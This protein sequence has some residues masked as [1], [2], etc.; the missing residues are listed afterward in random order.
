LYYTNSMRVFKNKLCNKWARKEGLTD[1]CLRVAAKEIAAGNVEASLGKKV[2]KKRIALDAGKRG[3]ARTVVAFQEGHNV[4][5]MYGF[6]KNV[7]STITD[8]E[9][10]SLQDLARDYLAYSNKQLNDEVKSKHLFEIKEVKG[11]E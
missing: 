5:F 4:F 9:L 10:K 2:F 7:R 8:K 3:G 1:E 11:N 6:E